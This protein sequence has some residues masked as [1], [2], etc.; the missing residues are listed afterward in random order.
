MLFRMLTRRRSAKAAKIRATQ[1]LQS[2]LFKLP[3]D[4]LVSCFEWLDTGD[5]LRA[6]E[7][8]QSWNKWINQDRLWK[9]LAAAKFGANVIKSARQKPKTA[10]V[11]VTRQVDKISRAEHWINCLL[12]ASRQGYERLVSSII[13]KHKDHLAQHH[14]QLRSSV[15]YLAAHYGHINLAKL[16]ISAGFPVDSVNGHG[17]CALS[18]AV[19]VYG[20]NPACTELV[21]MLLEA[22]CSVNRPF[23]SVP[24][25]YFAVQSRSSKAVSLLLE[26]K[27]DPNAVTRDLHGRGRESVLQC[28]LRLGSP[29][30]AM[31]LLDAKADPNL[32]LDNTQHPLNLAIRS[33]DLSPVQM[34]AVIERLMQQLQ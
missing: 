16:L 22:K 30:V 8:C 25:L 23:P 34:P 14:P 2:S 15:L 18:Q 28:S 33:F 6:S 5:R 1:Q 21:H 7:S 12:W 9:Q 24:P 19:G 31:L 26:R 13:E 32:H 4:V 17:G 10:V 11:R 3:T 29:N 20:K 27:A